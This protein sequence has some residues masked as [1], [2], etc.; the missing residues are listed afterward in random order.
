LVPGRRLP[1]DYSR[2]VPRRSTLLPAL[3]VVALPVLATGLAVG[4]A[5]GLPAGPAAA[6]VS[7][8]ARLEGDAPLAIT[9]DQL[10]P[11]SIPQKGKVR[12]SG[13]I[14]NESDETWSAINVHAFISPEPITDSTDLA[15]ESTRGPEEYVGDRITAPGT[16]VTIPELAPGASASYTDR[17]PV[18]VLDATEPGVYWFGVHALGTNADGRDMVADG[19]ART[20]LPY[21]PPQGRGKPVDTAL[22]VP[23]RRQVLHERDGRVAD[24]DA[25]LDTLDEG[26]Q[27]SSVLDFGVAAGGRPLT[28]L[29]DP[30]VPDAV[31]KLNQGNPARALVQHPAGEAGGPTDG[32]SPTEGGSAG[33]DAP[34]TPADQEEAS[35][36]ATSWLARF[37]SALSG[38][39]VL[40]LPWGDVDVAS[41]AEHAPTVYTDARAR[42]GTQIVQGSLA[43]DPVVSAPSGHLD[44]AA[45]D[46]TDA[47]TT[48]L[49]SDKSVVRGRAPSVASYAGH[50]LVMYA[51]DVLKGG[52]GPDDPL[53]AVAVRQRILGEA[54]LRMT[55]PGRQPL[56]VVFPPSW[57]PPGGPD[58]SDFFTGL[59][60]N[61][62][63]L[64]SLKEA[65][66][67]PARSL[68]ADRFVYP[69]WQLNH[70]V[71]ASAFTA[72]DALTDE[73]S[74]LQGVLTDDSDLTARIRAEAFGTVSYGARED[75][76]RSLL[77]TRDTIGWVQQQLRSI[78][79]SAPPRVILSSNSGSFS[80]TITN[81]L[82]E[83]VSVR[84][85]TT[86]TPPMEITIPDQLELGPD[87]STT[88]QLRASTDKLGVHDVAL[89]LTDPEG[90]ALGSPVGV[91]VRAAQVSQVIWL[92]MGVA[93]GLLLLAIVLRLVR[94][95]RGSG[96]S[97][98]ND[99]E[100]PPPVDD[101]SGLE[102][103]EPEPATT[104]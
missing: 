84:L 85:R 48:V 97:G 41:A 7:A 19:R 8:G 78:S 20:F 73:A 46:L 88:V 30:A 28:W 33:T 31:S 26:G 34:S 10:T 9:I 76:L 50:T 83:P 64:T 55:E 47:S 53:A 71:A 54:A 39:Q 44:Q 77:A 99:G 3:A 40:A 69:Q 22:V 52:P 56:V 94:R 63:R 38:K 5:V 103:R 49:V 45:M 35:R 59:D 61:W 13:L 4:P 16:F 80:V 75:D 18:S 62:M 11:S 12:I 74:R 37:Q 43:A 32:A 68:S 23:I 65:A 82:D 58:Y 104:P 14:T 86:S 15:F 17:I 2:G 42:S 101:P 72:L 27:L 36:V 93:G 96:P 70:E 98:G 102:A 67:V 29:V 25:W 89:S 95:I 66:Q 60:V 57:T 1:D 91:P 79:V 81:G 24:E 87:A 90:N 92:I 6:T 51:S 100:G 21:V